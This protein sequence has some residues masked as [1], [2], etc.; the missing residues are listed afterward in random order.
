ELAYG[1]ADRLGGL[2]GVVA[3]VSLLVA[4]ASAGLFAALRRR[5]LPPLP[6]L[7]LTLLSLPLTA[8]TWTARA[9][10]FTLLLALWW[11]ERLWRYRR[12]GDVRRLWALPL[13]MALWANLHGGFIV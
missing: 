8:V 2:N 6:A 11:S 13:A 4:L 3:L 9:Q 10:L 7:A 5:G 1:L 12:D